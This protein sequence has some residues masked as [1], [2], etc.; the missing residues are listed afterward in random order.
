MPAAFSILTYQK[1]IH[2]KQ[3]NNLS[4]MAKIYTALNKE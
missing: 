2:S 4:H 3:K 1:M